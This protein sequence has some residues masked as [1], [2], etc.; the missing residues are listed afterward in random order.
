MAS[1]DLT[2]QKYALQSNKIQLGANDWK[3]KIVILGSQIT[4]LSTTATDTFKICNLGQ[5]VRVT[6]L[7]TLV[8]DADDT[9]LTLKI[10]Y[11]DGTNTD[12]DAYD[13]DVALDSAAVTS[14]NAPDFTVDKLL[15]DV[16]VG[17]DFYMIL[18]FS[19]L[20]TLDDA[21]EFIIEFD[22]TNYNDAPYAATLNA[23]I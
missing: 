17:A 23:P 20:T 8:V 22:A 12:D 13:A 18:T 16:A 14:L 19:A 10:G 9:A 21:T 2:T 7:S 11:T 4:A 15:I 1:F 5:N 3:R 6:N